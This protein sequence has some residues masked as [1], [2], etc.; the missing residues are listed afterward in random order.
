MIITK[1]PLRVSLFGGGTDYPDWYRENGGAVLATT[2]NKYCYITCRYL[3]PFFPYKHRVVYSKV[4][5]VDSVDEIKHPA[6]RSILQAFSEERGLEIHYDA[7]LP[8]RTGVGSSS[9]FTVGF[10]LALKALKG[11]SIDKHK[12][13]KLAINLEQNV[14]KENVGA[15]DQILAAYG[16]FNKID[17]YKD[18]SFNVTPVIM[19]RERLNLLQDH[20]MLYFTGVTRVAS[21]IVGDQLNN[22]KN[23]VSHYEKIRELVDEAL[24]ILRDSSR[25]ISEIGKL[26]HESWQ[27]KREL[28]NTI[29]NP[30]IDKIYQAGIDAGAIGGK[31][32]GAGG[33]GFILFFAA[34]EH[35]ANIQ[36]KLKNLIYVP[37]RFE[38]LGSKI[39]VYEPNGFQ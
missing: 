16:N 21:D 32:L 20:F 14:M 3:P 27:V 31:I 39:V 33:G 35:Q 5:T 38:N 13:A 24:I 18:D 19:E 17:F 6:V 4:E 30:E 28:S 8:A 7:D 11:E 22:M 36:E 37:F 9:S 15:Q 12:L 23:V 10:I 29:T 26:L 25:S 2:I 1:T 34:P